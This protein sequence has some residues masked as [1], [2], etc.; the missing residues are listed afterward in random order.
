MKIII[1]LIIST[2]TYT[3]VKASCFSEALGYSCCEG[4][5]VVTTDENGI[6]NLSKIYKHIY[7]SK[8]YKHIY[9]YINYLI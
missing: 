2:I 5:S 8:I 1:A 6:F 9:I 7:I 4:C 3:T